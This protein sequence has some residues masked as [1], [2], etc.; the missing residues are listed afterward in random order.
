MDEKFIADCITELRIKK[1]IS[2]YQMSIELGRNKSYMQSISSG[3]TLPSMRQFLEI[4][5]YLE[6]TPCEFFDEEIH[7]L[8]LY[9]KA[10][11]MLKQL[12]DD[13]ILAVL[14]LLHQLI[15]KSNL[16]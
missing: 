11:A 9:Q 8:P 1:N 13:A 14:P 4:C 7:N 5:D 2:E 12:D 3:R 16:K 10:N 6:V 15:K